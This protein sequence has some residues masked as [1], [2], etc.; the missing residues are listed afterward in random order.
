[1]TDDEKADV[2]RETIDAY[3]AEVDTDDADL[4]S[5]DL[6]WTL[7]RALRRAEERAQARL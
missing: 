5:D 4:E 1:M 6:A 2:F 7:V 3:L